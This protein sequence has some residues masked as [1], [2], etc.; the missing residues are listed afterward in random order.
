LKSAFVTSD[1]EFEAA[2]TANMT[3]TIKT[4]DQPDA[5]KLEKGNAVRFTGTLESYDPDPAFML[6][7]DKAKVNEE[8]LPKPDKKPA[9]KPVKKP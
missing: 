5:A 2:T 7:W 8:D 3:A 6:H 9:K 1:A 4:T